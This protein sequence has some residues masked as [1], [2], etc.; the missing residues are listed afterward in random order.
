MHVGKIA[1]YESYDALGLADL[2]R[3]KEVKPEE[4]LD[5]ALARTERLNPKLNAIVHAVPDKARALIL[6]GLPDGPFTGV[7]FLLKDLGC[8]A[9]GY[10]THMGSRLYANY[11]WTFDSEI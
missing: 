11:Q 10:P 1:E 2:V 4:L 3:R 5:E 8:E 7:P 9:I 6:D